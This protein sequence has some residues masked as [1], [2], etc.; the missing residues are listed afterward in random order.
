VKSLGHGLGAANHFAADTLFGSGVFENQA[1]GEGQALLQNE[2]R[3]VVIDADGHGV[4][5]CGLALQRNMNV[6][7]HA[8]EDALAAAAF[9]VCLASFAI[10]QVNVG[11]DAAIVALLAAGAA[12]AWLTMEARRVRQVE[13]DW[14]S[15]HRGAR[16]RR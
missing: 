14:S 9:V 1:R 10:R 16:L 2:K 8:Q 12:L 11:I 13:R 15:A 3:A 5:G 6:G 4:E 7:A